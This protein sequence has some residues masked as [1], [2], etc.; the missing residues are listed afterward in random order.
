MWAELLPLCLLAVAQVAV[1]AAAVYG[2][3]V[4]IGVVLAALSQV[5]ETLSAW[6][7]LAGQ[8]WV[9]AVL[10]VVVVAALQDLAAA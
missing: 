3:F 2:L 6:Q 7:M 5:A 1:V 8:M 10:A 9:A 4:P